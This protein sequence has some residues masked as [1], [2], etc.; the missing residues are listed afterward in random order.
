MKT[1]LGFVCVL[2]VSLSACGGGSPAT[3][4]PV[5]PYPGDDV[6]GV[7]GPTSPPDPTLP[8]APGLVVAAQY[9]TPHD[10]YGLVNLTGVPLDRVGFSRE[11][12]YLPGLGYLADHG[13]FLFVPWCELAP[14]IP[15]EVPSYAHRPLD[16]VPHV[17]LTRDVLGRRYEALYVP[18][19]G[20]RGWIVTP[21]M[22]V[23]P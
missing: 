2:S 9:A 23:T 4:A 3:S 10:R 6:P 17:A 22:L 11:G 5:G 13:D 16:G 1:I 7:P 15:W 12:E 14:G 19:P 21:E 20:A 8:S 18:R